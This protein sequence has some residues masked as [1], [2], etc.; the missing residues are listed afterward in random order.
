MSTLATIAGQID[1]LLSS[2]SSIGSVLQIVLLAVAAGLL[3]VAALPG[4]RPWSGVALGAATVVLI[5]GELVL[6]WFHWRLYQLTPVVNPATGATTGHMAVPLWIESEKL[7]VWA[8]VTAT[9]SLFVRRQRAEL[10]P[11]IAVAVALFTAGAVLFGR[12]FTEPLPDFLGQYAGYLQGM[13]SGAPEAA[14]QAYAG[15][16]GSRQ[17]FYNTWYMWVHPPLLFFSYGCFTISFIATLGVIRHHRA[18][19]ETTAYRWARLG[20]LTL[21]LGMLLG[22][23]WA[24]AAWQGEAWW[25]SGKI[26][27]SLM[28]WLLYTAYLHG[29]LY[30][31]RRGMWRWVVALSV[32]SFTVLVLTYVTTY[33]VPG[34][35]SYASAVARGGL[36]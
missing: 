29:R 16:E 27:M 3:L 12:P 33:V 18:S 4:T 30:L 32:L 23:P 6:V 11:G 31:R 21:T 24:L 19:W 8:L 7:Y 15:M 10:I 5:A 2:V 17:Y 9:L 28:M 35:H 22:L 20:Y 13:F 34:A 26:N 1:G 36:A 14:Q 25:W